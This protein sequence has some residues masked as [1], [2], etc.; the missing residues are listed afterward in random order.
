VVLTHNVR[1]DHDRRCWLQVSVGG[2]GH[3][4][5]VKCAYRLCAR[6]GLALPCCPFCRSTIAAFET[7]SAKE[8]A[9]QGH[10]P[11][12]ADSVASGPA[13]AAAERS[14]ECGCA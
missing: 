12:G 1:S 11:A 7:A 4:L 5:C 6:G 9:E 13:A 8:A 14:V 10:V 3:G 2:C